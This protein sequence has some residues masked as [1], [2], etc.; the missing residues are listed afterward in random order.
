MRFT[1]PVVSHH[2]KPL[3]IGG[4]FKL[5]VREDDCDKPFC[6]ILRDN[7]GGHQLLRLGELIGAFKLHHRLNG[8]KIN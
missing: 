1:G 6:H 8:F 2:Q 3:V 4:L 7:V 5:Q